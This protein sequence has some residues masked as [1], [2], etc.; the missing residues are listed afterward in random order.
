MLKKCFK[1]LFILLIVM[2]ILFSIINFSPKLSALD[3]G[4]ATPGGSTYN[5][6]TQSCNDP[7]NPNRNKILCITGGSSSCDPAYCN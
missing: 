5:K 6:V 4:Y 7:L 1:P 3:N 2:G